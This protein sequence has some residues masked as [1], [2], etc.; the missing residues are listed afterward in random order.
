MAGLANK[1]HAKETR[2]TPLR[3]YLP[4]TTTPRHLHSVRHYLAINTSRSQKRRIENI[5][6]ICRHNDFDILCGFETTASHNRMKQAQAQID[7][8]SH[9]NYYVCFTGDG[10]REHPC[11]NIRTEHFGDL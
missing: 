10:G 5:D 2:R 8:R 11:E 9:C 6:S 4:L 1:K 7:V 3:C